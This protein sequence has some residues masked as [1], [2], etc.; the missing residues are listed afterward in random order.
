[1]KKHRI[2][3]SAIL[4]S[5][6]CLVGCTNTESSTVRRAEDMVNGSNYAL[7]KDHANNV[8]G[9]GVSGIKG[10]TQK[11]EGTGLFDADENTYVEASISPKSIN[12]TV[13]SIVEFKIAVKT[14]QKLDD[15]GKPIFDEN[16]G[17]AHVVVTLKSA[18]GANGSLS[19]DP[20][21][22]DDKE[23]N[24]SQQLALIVKGGVASVRL[25]VGNAYSDSAP[26]YAVN[27]WSKD[28]SSPAVS[29]V[30][31]AS[32]QCTG[33]SCKPGDGD[34]TN[35]L[36]PN[37]DINTQI[38]E[39]DKPG[40]NLSGGGD[41][42]AKLMALDSTTQNLFINSAATFR[43][44]LCKETTKGC[45]GVANK[46]VCFS[47]VRGNNKKN[48]AE[49]VSVS[50]GEIPEDSVDGVFSAC[51]QTDSTGVY[52]VTLNAGSLYDAKYYLNFYHGSLAPVSYTINTQKPPEDV[53]DGGSIAIPTDDNGEHPDVIHLEDTGCASSD[54]EK[55]LK[56]EDIY[57]DCF[58]GNK[59]VCCVLENTDGTYTVCK[60]DTICKS[61]DCGCTE[62]DEYGKCTNSR[63][64]ECSNPVTTD[65]G[66][67]AHVVVEDDENG[68][69]YYVGTDTDGD[70]VPDVGPDPCK[71]M[72]CTENPTYKI[73]CSTDKKGSEVG[74]CK[75]YEDK[76]N[77]DLSVYIKVVDAETGEGVPGRT[78]NAK[79]DRGYYESN[80]ATL[81]G[82]S[83]KTDGYGVV[84]GGD[85]FLIKTGSGYDALYMLRV[86]S[87]KANPVIIP[88]SVLNS[89]PISGTE[90]DNPKD[91]EGE[92]I[93]TPDPNTGEIN[94]DD[95][96]VDPPG[97]MPENDPV[98][99]ENE[100]VTLAV[101]PADA[102]QVQTVPIVKTLNLRVIVTTED[103][104]PVSNTT[105]YWKVTRGDSTA[106]NAV[107]TG[108]TQKTDSNGIAMN[109]FYTGTGYN[110][111]Y[112]VS[113]FH[114]NY[115]DGDNPKS[116]SFV[117]TTENNTGSEPEADPNEQGP[118]II[119]GTDDNGNPCCTLQRDKNG[120]IKQPFMCVEC[121]VPEGEKTCQ[122]VVQKEPYH[123]NANACK[124]KDGVTTC[125][126]T[127]CKEEN[128][129]P[130]EVDFT[131]KD[132]DG[133][134]CCTK[135]KDKYRN[136]ITPV[137][138]L[139]CELNPETNTCVA[140]GTTYGACADITTPQDLDPTIGVEEVTGETGRPCCNKKLDKYGNIMLPLACE[141]ACVENTPDA[142][143]HRTC[144]K[145]SKIY[146]VCDAPI[147]TDNN[148]NICCTLN[149]SG[150][151]CVECT[152]DKANGETTCVKKIDGKD[153][154]YSI[155]ENLT[156]SAGNL[157]CDKVRDKNDNPVYPVQCTSA[158][159]CSPSEADPARMECRK[160]GDD[161]VY[162]VCA[163]MA[164]LPLTHEDEEALEN[165]VP[166]DPDTGMPCCTKV[167]DGYGNPTHPIQCE[168]CP[169][170]LSEGTKT[171]S[172]G[173]S[174]A[175]EYA[176]C[177]KV[178]TP[179]DKDIK[180]VDTDADGRPCCKKDRDQY[181]NIKKP[182]SCE[183]D[184]CITRDDKRTCKKE[185][186]N[187]IYGLCAD[188]ATVEE[189]IENQIQ[190]KD[191]NGNDCCTKKKDKFGNP[192]SPLQCEECKLDPGE[193]TCKADGKTYA[194]CSG[195]YTKKEYEE[196]K[197]HCQEH[198]RDPKC[199]QLI[200]SSNNPLKTTVDQSVT[201]TARLVHLG[202]SKP[203][204]YGVVGWV[205]D[206]RLDADGK[207]EGKFIS[208][209]LWEV[210]GGLTNEKGEHSVKFYTGSKETTYDIKAMV[211]IIGDPLKS[212]T[213]KTALA[214]VIIMPHST[215]VVPKDLKGLIYLTSS[216]G[217][218]A[219][220]IE[221][222]VASAEYNQC[223][224]EH[225]YGHVSCKGFANRT[226]QH[227]EDG[228]TRSTE[229]SQSSTAQT[230]IASDVTDNLMIY[231]VG[232]K[233]S[234]P[235]S[236]KCIDLSSFKDYVCE[237]KDGECSE[238]LYNRNDCHEKGENETVDDDH[239]TLKVVDE[240]LV[241]DPIPPTIATAP[242]NT[243]MKVDVGPVFGN[244]K[245]LD[246]SS[247]SKDYGS[248]GCVLKQVTEGYN[249]FSEPGGPT[250]EKISKF[251][252]HHIINELTKNA[253]AN[254]FEIVSGCE[255]NQCSPLKAKYE[256]DN[257][258]SEIDFNSCCECGKLIQWAR[259][260]SNNYCDDNSC[261]SKTDGF[262][263]NND[264][265]VLN[266]KEK[267]LENKIE[268]YIKDKLSDDYCNLLDGIQFITVT[269]NT[270]ISKDFSGKTK[271]KGIVI[272]F[273]NE[274]DETFTPVGYWDKGSF[275]IDNRELSISNYVVPLTGQFAYG[276]YI[277]K[278]FE[279]LIPEEVK[280]Q[281]NPNTINLF[282]LLDC[283][284][285]FAGGEDFG[286]AH[287][288]EKDMKKLCKTGLDQWTAGEIDISK[289]KQATMQ[290]N[291]DSVMT[292]SVPKGANCSGLF[293]AQ[294]C[295]RQF[296]QS[297]MTGTASFNGNTANVKGKWVGSTEKDDKSVT[298]N[299]KKL[300]KQ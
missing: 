134:T 25:H 77:N 40:G 50:N 257:G 161:R 106:N 252:A 164:E 2:T 145:D 151:N 126:F 31:V 171:C 286:S 30:Y 109:Q 159:T 176:V 91:P 82:D 105:T 181:G 180:P 167:R 261:T 193:T 118:D 94:P 232:M 89:L 143:G 158:Y 214:Q 241:L 292:F 15:Q 142:D 255:P 45:D 172:D 128:D 90:G 256:C 124:T 237:K 270:T 234:T 297:D 98:L 107:L 59:F 210:T 149:D 61:G 23:Q 186:D 222:H 267:E 153:V 66:D 121:D 271:H 243:R 49:I 293:G 87:D 136:I 202:K 37:D 47:F 114:P 191:E 58:D 296:N 177:A 260:C 42:N 60:D 57:K 112:V 182:V 122:A 46:L 74:P 93:V 67:N 132:E 83:G 115:K 140:G 250:N 178:I 230:I 29:S 165:A 88:I 291:L 72:V 272:E 266:A 34:T 215:T 104:K 247:V 160:S 238:S 189:Q 147:E 76:I 184:G 81:E 284:K 300:C 249:K 295:Y 276:K 131:V 54:W 123:S 288:D 5:L 44:K 289:V 4:L 13:N 206:K 97:D 110:S 204:H 17:A 220:T 56:D 141:E 294:R 20:K 137:E 102:E 273:A 133:N 52:S 221:Y 21:I 100:K 170:A 16:P 70:T 216:D 14:A 245:E 24:T 33:S 156:D 38:T 80:N 281:E 169:T 139:E 129:D 125:T 138:C 211:P 187:V 254:C 179:K 35:V 195:N 173:A 168:E 262:R 223:S 190:D 120:N 240:D 275:D 86:S 92:D 209:L 62:R 146:D 290:L 28:S 242:Y 152:V 253:E 212:S 264:A 259:K 265:S 154:T 63:A 101:Y 43:V 162:G 166:V 175:T 203:V 258:F 218:G 64:S 19:A 268:S 65:D 279:N 111:T 150:T 135:K 11:P 199:Y 116:V 227:F 18:N 71:W 188:I 205:R 231:A 280:N 113:V 103:G 229:A 207:F 51:S 99:N 27:V 84:D 119:N 192:L 69:D 213:I 3:E 283:G 198:P 148:G 246:C 239:C 32:N 85:K 55:V 1:M 278:S 244:F 248:L 287:I 130:S 155:C 7:G 53:G 36:Q 196:T 41:D 285:I 228:C 22:L 48:G 12:T 183:A 235:A 73:L 79:L 219:N 96:D 277:Y 274:L 233:G 75:K 194:L 8:Y 226:S 117:V 108:N 174:P 6:L 26:V 78:V 201:L 68:D 269:G 225:A 144:T 224:V 208:I 298:L 299:T 185:G 127:M 200:I 263:D 163:D 10:D 217:N 9:V 95:I 157:C 39:Q 236:Y 197:A 282:N 251:I